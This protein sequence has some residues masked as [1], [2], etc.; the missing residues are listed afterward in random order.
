MRRLVLHIGMPKTGT[1][2][3]EAERNNRGARE[4]RRK[5]IRKHGFFDAN[6]ARSYEA[7]LMQVCFNYNEFYPTE[8]YRSIHHDFDAQNE[9]YKRVAL[10]YDPLCV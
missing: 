8:E 4:V 7:N 9:H 6:W 5:N 1:C 3:I 10:T 2:S